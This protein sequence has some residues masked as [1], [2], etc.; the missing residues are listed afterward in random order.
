MF[1]L[2]IWFILLHLNGKGRIDTGVFILLT[3][4]LLFSCSS[5]VNS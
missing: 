3:V 5:Q 4:L 2:L 1:E